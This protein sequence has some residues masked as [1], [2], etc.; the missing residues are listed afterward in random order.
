MSNISTYL[1]NALL[2]AVLRNTAY[3]S[4]ATVYVGLFTTQCTASGPGAE[5]SGGSYARQAVTFSA[6]SSGAT[7]NSGTVTFPTATANWGTLVSWA[8]FDA[9]TAGNMLF[10]GSLVGQNEVQ[11]LTVT[12][13]PTGGTFTL[14]FGGQ[15]T[16]PI[17]YN[18]TATQLEEYLESLVNIGDGNITVSGANGGPWTATFTGTLGSAAQSLITLTVNSLTGGTSPT[19]NVVETTQGATGNKTINTSDALSFAATKL[20]VS[21]S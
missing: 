11:T 5:V 10:F 9:A 15:T 17:A 19:V 2:N 21:L 20:S 16:P 3:T 13:A 7:S 8:I 1:E 14:S 12:G 18:S 4:P 6:P